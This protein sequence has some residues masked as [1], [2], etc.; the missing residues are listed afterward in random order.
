MSNPKKPARLCIRH[1]RGRESVWVVRNGKA[2]TSTGCREGDLPKAEKFFAEWLEKHVRPNTKERN[3]ANIL[4][5]EVLNLY[6]TEHAP[7]KASAATIGYHVSHLSEFWGAR[8]LL[9]VRGADCREYTALRQSSGCKPATVRRE[10]KT[11][12][13]AVNHWGREYSTGMAMP[14]VSLPP[15]SPPKLLCFERADIAKMLWACRKRKL[16]YVAR[17][18]LIGLYTGTRRGAI[19]SLKWHRS[20]SSGYYDSG[21]GILYRRGDGEKETSKRRPPCTVPQPLRGFLQRWRRQDEDCGFPQI[22][23]YQGQPVRFQTLSRGFAAVVGE[24]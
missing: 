23:H 8:T 13:A 6:A 20:L 10:L 3:L 19:L 22:I 15:D 11:L 12:Q 7:T 21:R 1:R 4:I 17:F 24:R 9:D 5:Q 18:I 14:R 16:P 2:E